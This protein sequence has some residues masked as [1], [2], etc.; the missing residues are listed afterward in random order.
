M[1]RRI[2]IVMI[3]GLGLSA[4]GPTA[5]AHDDGKG[6]SHPPSLAAQ[7]H[8]FANVNAAKSNAGSNAPK[9]FAPC[10]RGMAAKTFPCDRV[11]MMSHL[12]LNDLGLRF[13]NDIWGWTDPRT[14]AEYA[15]I[16]GIEGTVFV[17]ISDPKR[18]DVVGTLP[19][20]S[21]EGGQFWRD[22]K[23]YDDHAFI[24]SEHDDHGMQVFDLTRLRGANGT[25]AT[26]AETAHYAGV[27]GSHNVNINVDTGF[28]YIVGSDECDGGLHMVD[29]HDP[30]DPTVAGC[31]AENGYVHDTQCEIYTGP[32]TDHQGREICFNSAATFN[33]FSPEGIINTVGI[34]DV[35]DKSAPV[36][37]SS[38][39]YP[40]DGY[41]HQ[42]WLT[43][44]QEYF[45]H[46]DELDEIFYQIPTTTRIFDVRDLDNPTLTATT[47][48][49][50]SSIGHNL[51]TEGDRA[52]AS[53]Y[54][55]GLRIFD[56]AGVGAGELPEVGY[57]DVYPENDNATFEGGT[58]SNY[59]YYD[60]R[61]VAVSSIDRGLFVLKP[62]GNTGS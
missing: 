60:Q 56:T 22:I 21:T 26:F 49:G 51:Y 5:Y 10:I 59:P 48:N 18:P 25:P 24:V 23:I 4:V 37:L 9:S 41:S 45:L 46:N 30:T 31:S 50:E 7:A 57:F 3:M 13:A 11:D 47:D 2:A 29:V 32:D 6:N 20:H 28:A 43:P 42:G 40:L 15:I 38:F 8:E 36:L 35:T 27:G 55:T 52:Y 53:N 16:G 34:V 58:W 39:E 44:D 61:V 54:T 1:R 17:D 33:D 14:G 62:R 19:T 12:T